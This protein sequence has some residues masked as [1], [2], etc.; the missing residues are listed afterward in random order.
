MFKLCNLNDIIFVKLE[1]RGLT[2]YSTEQEEQIIVN[3]SKRRNSV[4]S[5][6]IGLIAGNIII[7]LVLYLLYTFL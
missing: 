6:V 4:I 3:T 5:T 7:C 2:Y 1:M